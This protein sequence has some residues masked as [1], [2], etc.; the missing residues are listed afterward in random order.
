MK[1][2]MDKY[3]QKGF[4]VQKA[5]LR[6]FHAQQVHLT[7]ILE[8]SQSINVFFVLRI[9]SMINWANLVAD[10][11]GHLQRLK[12]EAQVVYVKENFAHFLNRIH[13]V[14]AEVDMITLIL[15]LLIQKVLKIPCLIA[16]HWY[17]IDAT[18]RLNRET[19]M[20]TVLT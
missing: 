6:Q 3:V 19:S 4:T 17:L 18:Q 11:V 8:L 12:R 1:L 13:L 2:I 16:C 7:L 20:E 14:D 10:P 15:S 9:P 5:P